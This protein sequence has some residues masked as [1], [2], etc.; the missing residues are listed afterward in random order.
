[1]ATL[2][3]SLVAISSVEDFALEEHDGDADAM[4]SD[5]ISQASVIHVLGHGE[6]V[7]KLVG[8]KVQIVRRKHFEL[9]GGGKSL[10]ICHWGW[11]FLGVK[12]LPST[13]SPQFF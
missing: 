11:S 8:F 6:K 10:H 13:S 4:S 12:P 7:G 3:R 5:V 1:M 2:L 9:G